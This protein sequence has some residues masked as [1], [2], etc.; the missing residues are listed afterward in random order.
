MSDIPSLFDSSTVMDPGSDSASPS[1]V[2][3]EQHDHGEHGEPT[4]SQSLGD[5]TPQ[6]QGKAAS[7]KVSNTPLQKLAVSS[8][9]PF[10][11]LPQTGHSQKWTLT[12]PVTQS[13]S[14]TTAAVE[15][16]DDLLVSTRLS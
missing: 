9:Y 7:D 1:D 8:P 6:S 11:A 3:L 16:Y 2:E 4:Q 13:P 12:E 15:R 10:I 5:T 14:V